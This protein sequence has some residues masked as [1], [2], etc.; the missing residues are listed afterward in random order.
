MDRLWAPW[1]LSYVAGARPTDEKDSCFLCRGLADQNDRENLLVW[2]GSHSVVVLN[3][4]PY[5]NGHLLIAPNAHKAELH[6]LSVEES[7]EMQQV[8]AKLIGLLRGMMKPDGFNIGMN[9]GRAAGAGL[10]GHLHWHV[11]PRW[12]GDTNFMAVCADTRVIVQSLDELY[13]LLTT[14]LAE[15]QG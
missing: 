8:M 6:D 15:A 3:R 13:T 5:N 4:F 11:V 1:R 2:R 10:P 12:S 7:T 14:R 9:L